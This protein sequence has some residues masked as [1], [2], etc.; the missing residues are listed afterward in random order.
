VRAHTPVLSLRPYAAYSIS[1]VV[2]RTISYSTPLSR[3]CPLSLSFG[4]QVVQ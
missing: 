3:A 4:T 2:F 1:Y